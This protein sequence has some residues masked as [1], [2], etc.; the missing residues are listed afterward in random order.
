MDPASS[1]L[2][3]WLEVA[4]LRPGDRQRSQP[5]PE[6]RQPGELAM[7]TNQI[8]SGVEDLNL[9]EVEGKLQFRT[10]GGT[11]ASKAIDLR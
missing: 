9:K 5:V 10:S 4:I 11:V 3:H 2:N 8:A 1:P 7:N 6:A